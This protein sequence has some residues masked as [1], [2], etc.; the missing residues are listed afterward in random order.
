MAA[1]DEAKKALALTLRRIGAFPAEARE[2]CLSVL[3]QHGPDL[4]GEWSQ[5]IMAVPG[6]SYQQLG[7]TQ[8]G[9]LQV[10]APN[11]CALRNPNG[12]ETA[13]SS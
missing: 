11:G 3:E 6:T 10:I 9:Q 8:I 4:A 7:M 12:V 5:S 2:K 1:E 13:S